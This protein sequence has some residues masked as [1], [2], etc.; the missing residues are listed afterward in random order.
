M[1]DRCREIFVGR[2]QNAYMDGNRIYA[3]DPLKFALLSSRRAMFSFF[4]LSSARLRSSMS[5]PV[6]PSPIT[7]GKICT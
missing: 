4:V 6:A 1:G 7:F 5:V 3:S 2:G